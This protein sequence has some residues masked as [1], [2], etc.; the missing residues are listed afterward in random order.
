L[1]GLDGGDDRIM[2]A[3]R[4]DDEVSNSSGG[5]CADDAG[6]ECAAVGIRK[7]RFRTTHPC[8]VTRSEDDRSDHIQDG[9]STQ[10]DGHDVNRSTRVIQDT[11]ESCLI[12]T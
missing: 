10:R 6:D 11:K 1:V 5:E 3:A 8:G 2:L 12:R 7:E 9:N 4:D